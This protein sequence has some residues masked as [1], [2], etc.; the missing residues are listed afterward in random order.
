MTTTILMTGETLGRGDDA[1][2]RRLATKLLHQLSTLPDKPHTIVFYNSAVRLLLEASPAHEALGALEREGVDL[3]ACGT[4]V[5]H[6]GLN[7]QLGVGR[8]SDMREIA[9]TM[10]AADKVVTV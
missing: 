1:L 2:G 7:G 8:V 4:C 9:T 5:E 3:V 10:L 6:F